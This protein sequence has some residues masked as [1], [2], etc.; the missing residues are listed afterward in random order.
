MNSEKQGN[1][2]KIEFGDGQI[3]EIQATDAIV[4]LKLNDWKDEEIILKFTG[5]AGLEAF[6]P[7]G[8]DLSHG[9]VDQSSPFIDTVCANTGADRENVFC[10]SIWSAWRESPIIRLVATA[11][12]QTAKMEIPANSEKSGQPRN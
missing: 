7:L 6:S 12:E 8:E 10:F 2:Q 9:T 5:V 4:Y 1:F 11:F 3:L